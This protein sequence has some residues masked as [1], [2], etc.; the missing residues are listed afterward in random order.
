MVRADTRTLSINK[1]SEAESPSV[2][3]TGT[4]LHARTR[5]AS[6]LV[7]LR[8]EPCVAGRRSPMCIVTRCT[9]VSTAKPR[10]SR[11]AVV[12][13]RSLLH[14][15]DLEHDCCLL[16]KNLTQLQ[17]KSAKTNERMRIRSTKIG[18]QA[19]SGVKK[20]SRKVQDASPA[21]KMT[22][23]EQAQPSSTARAWQRH[24]G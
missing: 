23:W 7:L 1:L 21:G 9:L 22:S 6:T 8:E 19:A 4:S 11:L 10:S 3:S 18:V 16:G 5:R 20:R 15:D 13:R 12:R 24:G 14:G 17:T 2:H